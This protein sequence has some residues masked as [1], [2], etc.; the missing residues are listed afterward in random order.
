MRK[1][2]FGDNLEVMKELHQ[3]HPNGFIDLIYIDPPFNSKRNYNILYED[4]EM[5][6]TQAQKQ[7]FADTWSNVS[8]YDTLNEL[9][10]VDLDIHK[11]L[12]MLDNLSNISKSAI[13]YLTTMAIRI[14]YM[15][16]LLKETGSFY[17]HCDPNM[18]HYL[19]ILCDMIFGEKRFNNEI[20]WNRTNAHNMK[21]N[22][23]GRTHDIIFFYHKSDSYT[24]NN[25][26]LE[27]SKAQLKRFKKDERGKLYKAE[28]ITMTS[29][30][31]GRQFE[32]RGT[33]PPPNRSWG[34]S[35]EKLEELWQKGLILTKKD[36]TP[37][38]DGL[39]VYLDDLEGKLLNDNWHDIPR[40]GNT[41]K[42]RLGYPTQKPEALLERIIKASSNEGDLVADFF[43]GCGTTMAVAEK[44]NRRWLGVDISH[45]AVRLIVKRLSDP[46]EGESQ[47]RIITSTS[48]KTSL[49][50]LRSLPLHFA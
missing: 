22:Y 6:D 8:Y 43:C 26:Y 30:N 20:V 27:Y 44:M 31:P 16:R 12:T 21:S 36:G 33:I 15:H 41:S 38:L 48:Q 2:Y 7:A 40:V 5:E 19:K 39:K 17:L 49:P 18:S 28:N 3:K 24:W 4:I 35:E 46:Y 9:A 29:A 1:L 45:L 13:S 42:E 32:W 25:Q 11:F 47:Q 14:I 50:G 34:M 10:D 23:F 37:R